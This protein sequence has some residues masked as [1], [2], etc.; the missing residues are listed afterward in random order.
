M[1]RISIILT[2]LLSIAGYL[3]AQQLGSKIY[4]SPQVYK[5]MTKKTLYVRLIDDSEEYFQDHLKK[6]NKKAKREEYFKHVN[7]YNEIMQRVINQHWKLN[8][9]I[10][11][12][13]VKGLKEGV[14]EGAVDLY[15]ARSPIPTSSPE[16][17]YTRIEKRR[18]VDYKMYVPRTLVRWDQKVDETEIIFLIR[19]MQANIKA[20]ME[21]GKKIIPNSFYKQQIEKNCSKIKDKTLLISKSQV[22][23]GLSYSDIKASYPYEVSLATEEEIVEKINNKD[24]N[25]A[26]VF[27][28]PFGLGKGFVGG[29]RYFGGF[30]LIVDCT[31]GE[32]MGI[33]GSRS[34]LILQDKDF[35]KLSK[36]K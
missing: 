17:S 18:M 4:G 24:D 21:A 20:M 15:R 23:P 10:K 32:V 22:L 11:F 1:Q 29:E 19:F 36:C 9:N 2:I 5:E 27:L 28:L 8:K 31:T 12:I 7:S 16:M 6:H 26:Y 35:K 25:Y 30:K 3:Q 14:P 34:Y 13:K 33:L